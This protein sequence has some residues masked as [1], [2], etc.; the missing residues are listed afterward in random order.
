MNTNKIPKILKN[1]DGIITVSEFSKL[2]ISKEF[3]FPLNKI[4]V[5]HLAA[6]EI[7]KPINRAYCKKFIKE[8]ELDKFTKLLLVETSTFGVRYQKL[9]R[10]MLERKFEKIETKYGNIQIKLGY[11]NGELIK[12][13]PEYEDCK[14]IAKKENLPLI[15]VFNE[16]NCIISEKFFFNC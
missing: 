1:C 10:V 15:K 5:T 6:E 7:Y 8:K 16:I 4:F 12:V 3:N 11:L 2:D 9:K 14:I 13:T